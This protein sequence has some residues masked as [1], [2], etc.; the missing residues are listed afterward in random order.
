MDQQPYCDCR[1]REEFTGIDF[2]LGVTSSAMENF[3][4]PELRPK[5]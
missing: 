3:K 2:L 1:N 4:A 5:E